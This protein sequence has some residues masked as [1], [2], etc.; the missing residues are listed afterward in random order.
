MKTQHATPARTKAKTTF[1]HAL[2]LEAVELGT[3]H[4]GLV[5]HL[6]AWRGAHEAATLRVAA[7]T[8]RIDA[9]I[10]RIEARLAQR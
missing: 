6:D 8:A 7:V 5:R 3:L 2:E 1:A 10:E 4:T 9:A